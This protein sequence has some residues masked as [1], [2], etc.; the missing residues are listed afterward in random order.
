M[1][2]SRRHRHSR[3]ESAF[4]EESV[5]FRNSAG[6][7]LRGT[8]LYRWSESPFSSPQ[9]AQHAHN[10]HK[11]HHYST[12]YS[13]APIS[14]VP[15]PFP[16][17]IAS[18]PSSSPPSDSS[19]PNS[20]TL[21]PSTPSALSTALADLKIDT[22]TLSRASSRNSSPV[23]SP[24][25]AV[26]RTNGSLS[27]TASPPSTYHPVAGS[28]GPP[29]PSFASALTPP[30]AASAQLVLQQQPPA[31]PPLS[32]TPQ[33]VPLPAPAPRVV[34]VCH[35]MAVHSQW[36]FIPELCDSMLKE[37]AGLSAVFRFDFTGCGQSEGDFDFGGYS[38]QLDDI[39]C[40]V[41]AMRSRGYAAHALVGHSM[42]GNCALLYASS[43]H[44]IPNIVNINGRYQMTRGLPFGPEQLTALQQQGWF[45]WKPRGA[46]LDTVKVTQETINERLSLDMDCVRRIATKDEYG[47]YRVRVLTVH[48]NNDAVVPVQDAHQYAELIN[49][50]TLRTLDDCDHNY[51]TQQAKLMLVT[52]VCEWMSREA[53]SEK[54]HSTGAL[55]AAD[56]GH[57]SPNRSS[58]LP[59]PHPHPIHST[60]VQTSVTAA[61]L[62]TSA[63]TSA[64]SAI[65]P[66]TSSPLSTSP[67]SSSALAKGLLSHRRS[68]SL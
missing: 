45:I 40:A 49:N 32:S 3:A 16:F 17:S 39:H 15:P 12:P 56:S 58:T 20:T 14:T 13:P 10:S 30:Q 47:H 6:L 5:V 1:S 4:R 42:G 19:H 9:H 53:A 25:H 54:R 7:L 34:I 18:T 68:P 60:P 52:T 43:H 44:D 11:A 27:V 31:T 36:G 8:L 21:S 24:Q 35:G 50:H 41:A 51:S 37:V 48:G 28:G 55:N 2:E 61:A 33:P 29:S 65:S 38:K 63:S 64:I 22:P 23:G 46:T 62:P 26:R 66:T 67:S 57:S 59:P